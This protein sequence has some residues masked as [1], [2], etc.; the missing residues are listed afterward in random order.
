MK[1]PVW[2]RIV[3]R[4]VHRSKESDI[5]RDTRRAKDKARDMTK[6]SKAIGSYRE[7]SD[8]KDRK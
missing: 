1:V 7:R 8:K 6:A 5:N 3:V 2:L 4:D